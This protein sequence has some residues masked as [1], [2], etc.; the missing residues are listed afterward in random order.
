MSRYLLDT[1]IV[2]A[3]LGASALAIRLVGPWIATGEAATSIL[4]YAE[5]NE[6]FKRRPNYSAH[7]RALKT[8]LRIVTP[9]PLTLRALDRYSDIRLHLRPL[10]QLI[11]DVD[12]L[13]AATA[14]VRGLTVV[15]ADAHFQRVPGLSVQLISRTQL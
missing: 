3:Y 4:V 14:L 10:N 11:G 6:Y 1:N 9:Y 5:V 13:I 8:L 2:S 12:T 15:T 7:H